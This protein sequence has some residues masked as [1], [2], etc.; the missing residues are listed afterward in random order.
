MSVVDSYLILTISKVSN[1]LISGAGQLGSRYLQ[2]LI[3]C[4]L[5]L[6]IYVQDIYHESLY[7]AKQRWNEVFIPETLHEVSFRTSLDS[8][9]QEIDIAIVAT[10]ADV[11]P[12][13]Y[14][15]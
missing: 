14:I 13:E 7:R 3:K 10:T 9:P 6:R 5:P 2:G 11:R 1:I 4:R 12:N 15:G 8:L